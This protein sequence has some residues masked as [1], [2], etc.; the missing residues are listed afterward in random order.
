MTRAERRELQ[1]KQRAAKKEKEAAAPAGDGAGGKGKAKAG[2]SSAKATTSQNAQP[3]GTPSKDAG[4]DAPGSQDPDGPRGQRIFSHFGSQ[5][6]PSSG[7]TPSS[8]PI[9]PAVIRLGLQFSEFKIVG[10]NARCIATLTALRNV[11]QDYSTPANTTLSRHLEKHLG[12]QITH[13]VS[14]RPMA[15]TMGNAI[16]QLK[17]YISECDIDLPDK[18]AKDLLCD[19]IDTYIR[20]RIVLADQVIVENAVKKINDGDTV[21]TYARSSA[22]QKILLG[23]HGEGKNISVVVV[24]SRPLLEG[25]NLLSVL[26]NAG[27]PCTY[28]LLPSLG[29]YLS[30]HSGNISSVLLGAHSIHADGA[31]FSRS[32]TALVAMMARTHTIPVLVAC[33]TYKF[34]EA[35]V[36]DG[37][38]KNELGDLSVFPPYPSVIPNSKL[39]RERSPNSK[40]ELFNPLYDLT[41]A[42]DIT[43]VVTEVGIIPASSI[44][45]IPLALGR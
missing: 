25:K 42:K 30:S 32:G 19:K 45:L 34:S 18:D 8:D 35:V 44:S 33:E 7:K 22:V 14:A 13:L 9:H 10:A 2:A 20:D 23:A 38:T 21:L 39:L 1:E 4:R 31:V 6:P 40:L 16:R 41:S 5:K 11:I 29:S 36:L 15:V 27:I 12:P 24:D 37:F 43:A 17:K 28:M 26:T 3:S